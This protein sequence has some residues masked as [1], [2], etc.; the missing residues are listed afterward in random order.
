MKNLQQQILE[1]PT[2]LQ[3]HIYEYNVEHRIFYKYVMKE[4]EYIFTCSLCK[5]ISGKRIRCKNNSYC[6]IFCSM[7][8]GLIGGLRYYN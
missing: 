8:P 7:I 4:L 6:S 2:V 1:L 5:K 3:D